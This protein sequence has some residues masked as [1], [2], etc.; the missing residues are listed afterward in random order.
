MTTALAIIRIIARFLGYA[1]L[2]LVCI[3]LLG[4][5]FV[6]LTPVGARL[7]AD[8]VARLASTPD[9]QVALGQPSGL[10]SGRLRLDSVIISDTKGAY[11]EL[12]DIAVD[13]SPLSLLRGT[14][15]ADQV[16]AGLVSVER[17]P[18]VTE[19]APPA[20]PDNSGGGLPVALEIERLQFPD[21]RLGADLTGD[22]YRLQARGA[23]TADRDRIEST[24]DVNRADVAQAG[25]HVVFAFAPSQNRLELNARVAEPAGGLIAGLLRLPNKPALAFD[26][27]GE[28]PLSDWSGK[29][30][31]ALDGKPVLS[32]DGRHQA[33]T[34]GGH[35]LIVKGG[36]SFDSILPPAFRP[37]FAGTTDIDLSASLGVDGRLTVDNSRLTTGN[38]DLVAAGTFDP[39]G[40]NDLNAR[41]TGK[42]GPIDFRWPLADG[43]ARVLIDSAT[44]GVTGP[45]NAAKLDLAAAFTAVDL[46][47]GHLGGLH[48]QARSDA[49]DLAARSGR[50]ASRLSIDETKFVS[51][52]IDRAVRGPIQ[53]TAPISVSGDVIVFQPL[54]LES[55]SLGGTATGQYDLATGGLTTDLRLF[56]VPGLLPPGLAEKFGGTIAIA[57][58][59][60]TAEGGAVNL[61]DFSLQSDA[62]QAS[63]AV[64][65]D[66]DKTVQAA[67]TGNLP[68]IGKWLANGKGAASFT[69]SAAGPLSAPTV[70]ATVA[71]D[72]A[73]LAGRKVVNLS[74]AANGTASVETPSG[75]IAGNGSIAGQPIQIDASLDGKGGTVTV[76]TLKLSVGPNHVDGQLAFTPEFL[77]EGKLN[78]DL[79]DLG[80]VFALLGQQAEGDLKGSATIGHQ[81][82]RIQA[83]VT[84]GGNGLRTDAVQLLKPDIDLTISDLKSLVAKGRINAEAIEEGS[85][86]IDA[87]TVDIAQQ[88][89]STDFSLNAQYDGAPLQLRGNARTTDGA[90]AIGL[91]AVGASPRGIALSLADPTTITVENGVV[92]V[93]A[94]TMRVGDG[95][96]TADGTAGSELALNVRAVDLPASLVKQFMPGTSVDGLVSA[97]A[98]I[99]GPASAPLLKFDMSAPLKTLELPQGRFEDVSVTAKAEN[100]TLAGPTGV[101]DTRVQI[102]SATLNN[103][104]LTRALTG[105]ITIEGPVALLEGKLAFNGPRLTTANLDGTV[106]GVYDI[107]NKTATA[108]V[109]LSAKPEALPPGLAGKFNE[110]VNVNAAI[111]AIVGGVIQV[112]SLAIRSK[113]L[114]A[115][116]KA[117]L[118][119]AQEVSAT[120]TG[121]LPDLGKLLADAKGEARFDLTATGPLSAPNV[122]LSL[123]ADRAELAGR[124]LTG[125]SLTADALADVNAPQATVKASGSLG[126]QAID[127]D[128]HLATTEG[129][130]ALDRLSAVIGRNRIDGAL[131]FTPSFLPQGTL[132]FDLPD[133]GL[134]AALAGQK[135]S[136]DLKGAVDLAVD[137]EKLRATIN[138]SGSGI[139]QDALS[140]VNPVIDVRVND[141]STLNAEG[142]IKAKEIVSGE[143][144][145]D[146]L[147]LTASQD[148]GR[149]DFNVKANYDGA[150]AV[151]AGNLKNDNGTWTIG[152]N[153]LA[154]APRR[155]ALKLDAPSVIRFGKDGVQLSN[156][157][158]RAGNG[159]ISVTGTSGTG[160]ALDARI[161]NLPASLANAVVPSLGAEGTISG[162][163]A[164]RGTTAS[165]QVDYQLNWAKAALTQTKS[166][167]VA[168]FDIRANGRLADN[169]LRI[170]TVLS[171]AGGLSLNGGGTVGI[172]GNQPL[173]LAFKGTVPFSLLAAQL[174]A[175]GLSLEGN[176]RI[177]LTIGGTAS[178]PAINGTVT[179]DGAKLVD[180][181]RNIAL[182]NIGL[183]VSIDREAATINRLTGKLAQGGT[184]AVTGRV[185]IAPGS[186]FPADL[187]VKLD[188]A[189]YVDGQLVATVVSG[190]LTLTGPVLS[191]P[192]LGGTLQLG[193]TSITVPEKLPASLSEINVQH[194]NAPADVRAQ[195]KK[196]KRDEGGGNGAQSSIGLNITISAPS[197]I[198]VRGRGI[199]AELGGELTVRGAASEPIVSGGFEMRRGRLIILN[200][201]L[202]FTNGKIGFGGS[203]TPTLD[204]AATNVSGSTTI[205]VSVSGAANDPTIGFSSSPAL[206]Q[207]EILAQLIFGQSMSKLSAL[208]IAQLADAASQ[209]AG[210][211]STSLFQSL[212]SKLGVD[213]LDIS[214]DEKG[215]ARVSAGKYLNSRTY[216]ELQGGGSSGGKAVINLD[217]GRGVK[218]RGEAGGDGEGAAGIFYEKEY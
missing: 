161:S 121:T 160:L 152:L 47:Q 178:A 36:G 120:L 73:E 62:V 50:I 125:L 109:E 5:L 131:A 102:R 103:A 123:A 86:R 17:P 200:K 145:I 212:R 11:A 100:L 63:G 88:A 98:E 105:P 85:N 90:L 49:F 28:G 55:G 146:G 124:A 170:D 129:K 96:I 56:A 148:Q 198:F 164:L 76:P 202:D 91:D 67:L 190:N 42:T 101:I 113:T 79:P 175:Q 187:T 171:G 195:A 194:R 155:I 14:F 8:Q 110:P 188:K 104:D 23:L 216:I 15:R 18:V 39:T 165:P 97:K 106:K 192:V 193:K 71:A 12:R 53:I 34:E 40:A 191:S 144:R 207:D 154:A 215:E 4:L 185:G 6:G 9:R 162:T 65:L 128:A 64:S 32:V 156:L 201:R 135:A 147:V 25:A 173:S 22:A 70:K 74:I 99:T 159:V 143:N 43:E 45:A 112:D 68:D 157:G 177:D 166:A 206:P 69:V 111:T 151:I 210:G 114:T 116:G 44:L 140:I 108:N 19:V 214:T 51:A 66:A 136:G 27:A 153:Q 158:I 169:V 13:W 30:S 107:A 16:S 182:N 150:P 203:L 172:S 57:G 89:D 93:P 196:I 127:V 61:T 82:G 137:G 132:N 94:L 149:T 205:T 37:L 72:E 81:D 130:I 176:A 58:K 163:V 183:T 133:L 134:M 48:L 167:G 84:A 179:A 35:H 126:G 117:S 75:T 218:L 168:A 211:R 3:A 24:L 204:M 142:T 80:L 217:V 213:D 83:T 197:Q 139:R 87:L 46:P 95:R 184:V 52:D 10:L 141:L 181:R 31:A 174:S 26:I 208:Q 60:S 1:V 21:I 33:T 180:V 29:L 189:A 78:F 7:A 199:D 209:L 2:A 41:L 115:E 138:A 54:A 92:T 38:L 77:P 122:K 119:A 186:N 20:P 118:S 59:L